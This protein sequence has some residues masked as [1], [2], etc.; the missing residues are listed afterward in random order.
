MS[1]ETEEIKVSLLIPTLDGVRLEIDGEFKTFQLRFDM[2]AN[3]KI[4]KEGRGLA[5][6]YDMYMTIA[7]TLKHFIWPRD[8]GL[9]T[10]QLLEGISFEQMEYINAK[11]QELLTLNRVNIPADPTNGLAA[12]LTTL[13]TSSGGSSKP[14]PDSASDLALL[15]SGTL[16]RPN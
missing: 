16:P 6:N 13:P 10:E 3:Y 4:A 15:S 14:A 2:L 5:D 8:H 9:T 11:I 7:V 12:E 1:D